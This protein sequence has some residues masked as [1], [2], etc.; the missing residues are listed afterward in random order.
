[1][2]GTLFVD[3]TEYSDKYTILKTFPGVSDNHLLP[4]DW[5]KSKGSVPYNMTFLR[6]DCTDVISAG[7]N[8]INILDVE[9]QKKTVSKIHYIYTDESN[10]VESIIEGVSFWGPAQN[11]NEA[12][13]IADSF[14]YKIT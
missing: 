8:N 9:I 5:W 11:A 12:K 3:G 14:G 1:M 7:L 2:K 6:T 4:P 10:Q 13:C